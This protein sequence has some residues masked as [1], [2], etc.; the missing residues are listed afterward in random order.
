MDVNCPGE[1]ESQTLICWGLTC[2][3]LVYC[4]G[5]SE[6]HTLICWGLT[7]NRLVYCPRGVTGGGDARVSNDWCIRKT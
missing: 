4:P 2:D 6:S 3:G 7:C 1:G 5:G